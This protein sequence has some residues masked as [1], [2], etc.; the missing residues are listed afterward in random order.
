MGERKCDKENENMKS[1]VSSPVTDGN[2]LTLV[3]YGARHPNIFL[4]GNKCICYLGMSL[5]KAFK[6]QHTQKIH[7]WSI[8]LRK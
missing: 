8:I 5:R 3:G 2:I 7:K 6:N 1:F 4:V